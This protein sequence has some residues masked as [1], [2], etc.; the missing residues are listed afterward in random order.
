MIS[1]FEAM[2]G[3]L[4]KLGASRQGFSHQ[5]TLLRISGH[6]FLQAPRVLQTEMFG[7]A[8]LFVV[9]EQP[10]QLPAIA[11]SMEG[12]LTGTLFSHSASEDDVLYDQ[13]APVLRRR[14][15]RLLNDKMP[16]GVAV[17]PSMNHGGPYP[18][19]GHPGLTAVGL[20]ASMLRFAALHC[21]DNLRQRRLP[22]VLRDRNPTGQVWRSI[23][24]AWTQGD[25]VG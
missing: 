2:A 13:V 16:P 8:C 18:A 3:L 9:A 12:N 19:T 23:D 10:E 22:P 6:S 21:Y 20:P 4:A 1:R 17:V 15:G 24:G 25:L 7:N 14:V 5:N 11:A